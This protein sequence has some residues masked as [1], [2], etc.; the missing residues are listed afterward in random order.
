MNLTKIFHGYAIACE[1]KTTQNVIGSTAVGQVRNLNKKV[2][3]LY[4]KYLVQPLILSQS[5]L[6]YNDSGR[7]TAPPEVVHFTAK[8]V[9]NLLDIQKKRLEQAWTLITPI[10]VALL[11]EELVKQEELEPTKEQIVKIMENN[12]KSLWTSSWRMTVEVA[13]RI[14]HH[15]S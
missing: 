5:E 1:G 12:L 2:K 3:E 15:L 13:M 6:G 8:D 4:P 9:L 11:I 7:R 14:F 10:H